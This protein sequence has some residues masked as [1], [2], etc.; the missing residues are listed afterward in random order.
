[1]FSIH[2]RGADF[3]HLASAL[4]GAASVFSRD[5]GGAA[6]AMTQPASPECLVSPTAARSAGGRPTG[7][8]T[9]LR[10][11]RDALKSLPPSSAD[12]D[13]FNVFQR[14]R[15][16]LETMLPVPLHDANVLILGCG[17]RYA[18]VLLYATCTRSAIGLDVRSAFYRDG[19]RALYRQ[20][21]RAGKSRPAAS[22]NAV[23]ERRGLRRYFRRL[24]RLCGRSLH[25]DA[26]ILHSYDGRRASL[27]DGGF[28]ATLSNAV[29]QHVMDLPAFFAEGWRLT[30]RGGISYHVL[31][32]YCSLSGSLRD[33]EFCIRYPWAH[34]RGMH[35]VNPRHLNSVRVGPMRE[36]FGRWFEDVAVTPLARNHAKKGEPDF[37][38]EHPE[39]LS[40]ALRDELRE[41][42]EEELLTRSYLLTG[43]KP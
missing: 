23:A 13:Y 6:F 30:A 22:Y 29:L 34:L 19:W 36:M 24:E 43:R 5:P 33:D 3:C 8:A 7:R 14:S 21:R 37:S 9:R 20:H 2:F 12:H 35:S 40:A 11:Y 39:L 32:N 4:F 1:L 16:D 42:P 38:Y 27:P 17:Y 10:S 25:H 26:A 15:R 28:H 18:D 31:H 41:Y